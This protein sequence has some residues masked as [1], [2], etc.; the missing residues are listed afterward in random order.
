MNTATP[1]LIRPLRADEAPALRALFHAAVHGLACRDYTPDQLNAWAPLAHDA[2]QWAARLQ[3]NQPWV[4]EVAGSAAGF[5]DLQPSGYIDQSFVAPAHAG[6]GV[7]QALMAHLHTQANIELP[8][9]EIDFDFMNLNQAAH[10]DREFAYIQTRLGVA[11]KTVVGHVSNPVV[12]E[13]LAVWM[14][15]TAGWAAYSS[16][17]AS[18]VKR[19]NW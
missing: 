18:A 13:Q 1:I 3:A 4:A 11:R 12:V 14:R 2:A 17:A 6:Q 8:W 9:A 10:G 15:A 16:R 19:R 7:G 5:A